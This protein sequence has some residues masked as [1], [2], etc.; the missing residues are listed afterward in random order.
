MK[1]ALFV[2]TYKDEMINFAATLK[3][4]GFDVSFLSKDYATKS[5]IISELDRMISN[6][7][8]GDSLILSISG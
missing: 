8:A 4:R 3:E 2:T 6:A 7:R 5:D 1:R